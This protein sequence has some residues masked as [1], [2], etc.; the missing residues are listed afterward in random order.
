[1]ADYYT[2][3]SLAFHCSPEEAQRLVAAFEVTPDTEELPACLLASFP[4]AIDNPDDAMSGFAALLDYPENAY[5]GADIS[6]S[7]DGVHIFGYEG[8]EVEI[9]AELIRRLAPSALPVR[10][11]WVGDCS[12]PRLDAY[13]GGFAV[14]R[15]EGITYGSL[16]ALLEEALGPS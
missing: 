14:M 7:D 10:F 9:I 16:D 8:P 2:K 12:K 6:R 13:N 15:A 4:P 3:L 5:L 11:I 1:M